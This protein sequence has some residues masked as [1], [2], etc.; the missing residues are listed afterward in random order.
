MGC[1]EWL[2][3]GV[4]MGLDI[5][6]AI[7]YFAARKQLFEVSFRNASAAL[8]SFHETYVDD[9]YYDMLKIMKTLVDIKYEGVV[10]LDHFVKM[11][12]GR[13]MYDA[14]GIGYMRAML[15]CAQRGYHV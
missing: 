6:G 10:P 8:P 1:G 9:G 3:G 11:V 4:A 12:G 2:E 13:R 14:F 5:P 7:R 15:Q